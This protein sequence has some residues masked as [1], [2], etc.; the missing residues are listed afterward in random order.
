MYNGKSFPLLVKKKKLIFWRPALQFPHDG[1]LLARHL[2]AAVWPVSFTKKK[3]IL[4]NV[5]HCET[6][7]RQSRS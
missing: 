7:K 2:L 4:K 5:K 3:H 6:K 1:V